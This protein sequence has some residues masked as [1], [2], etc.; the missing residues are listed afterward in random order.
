MEIDP[1][2]INEVI[3]IAEER[4]KRLTKWQTSMSVLEE[5]IAYL[6]EEHEKLQNLLDR[7]MKNKPKGTKSDSDIINE[8]AGL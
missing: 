7:L 5:R 3:L 1:E 4:N 2:V 6:E 8:L